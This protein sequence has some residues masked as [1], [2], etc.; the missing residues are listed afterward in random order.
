MVA[1]ASRA[2]AACCGLRACLTCRSRWLWGG[3]GRWV[4]SGIGSFWG[5]GG[6][7]GFGGCL[8]V[9]VVFRPFMI[10]AAD[11]VRDEDVGA[12]ENGEE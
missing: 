2:D 7:G 9:G 4:G 11:V 10:R 6:G 3:S 5:L 12:G 8:V 1:R